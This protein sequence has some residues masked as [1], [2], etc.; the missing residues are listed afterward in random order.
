MAVLKILIYHIFSNPQNHQHLQTESFESV[1][2]K[3][4]DDKSEEKDLG[5]I[6]SPPLYLQRYDKVIDFLNEDRWVHA[7]N[8]VVRSNNK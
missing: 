1:D 4:V 2:E 7:M 3:D 6:F 8:R 5:I